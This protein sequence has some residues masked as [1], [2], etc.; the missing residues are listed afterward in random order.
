MDKNNGIY[1]RNMSTDNGALKSVSFDAPRGMVTGLIGENG[2]GKS[3]VM[4]TLA[5][6]LPYRGI[7]AINGADVSKSSK[8]RRQRIG[9]VGGERSLPDSLTLRM[10]GRVL[11]R[12]FDEWDQGTFVKLTDGFFLPDNKPIGEFSTGMKA[13]AAIAAALSHGADTLLLDEPTSG[14]DIA[15]RSEVL[16][17]IYD[18]MQDESHTVLITSHITSDLEKLCDRIAVI[19]DG[20]VVLEADKDELLERYVILHGDAPGAQRVKV[21]KRIYGEDVLAEREGLPD[22]ADAERVTLDELLMFFIKGEDAK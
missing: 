11:E 7:A 15:V 10:L 4:R 6:I 19:A 3:T 16:G 13:K 14:L 12:T 20:R 21:L 5:G 9:Y 8:D 22:G 18:F 1:V 2:A 17:L